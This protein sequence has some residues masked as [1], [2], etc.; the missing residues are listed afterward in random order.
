MYS[1]LGSYRAILFQKTA[2]KSTKAHQKKTLKNFATAK[3]RNLAKYEK[4]LGY[5]EM[6]PGHHDDL[7]NRMAKL[8]KLTRW[9]VDGDLDNQL[10]GVVVHEG[11]HAIYLQNNL[12]D[13]WYDNIR[14]LVGPDLSSN[15]KCATVSE[16]GMTEMGE[17]FA[18]V[19]V[20]VEFGVEIDPDVKQAYLNTMETIK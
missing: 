1:Y 6:N 20:A 8:E 19:G 15:I 12:R 18:E 16:Y 17:L 13:A 7:R 9:V 11:H 10:L 4:Y 3:D 14:T 5:K 2:T